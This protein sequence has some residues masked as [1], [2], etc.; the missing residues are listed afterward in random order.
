[1]TGQTMTM[2]SNNRKA[3]RYYRWQ[4]TAIKGTP[5]PNDGYVQAAEFV[6]QYNGTDRTTITSS[7]TATNPSG[8]SPTGEEPPKLIDNNLATK[9][10]DFNFTTNGN[11][12]N[13]V[14]TFTSSY[15]FTGYRWATANDA[16]ARDPKS[17]TLAG[18]PDGTNW[19]TLHTV[20]NF[21]ATVAR[22]TWQTAQTY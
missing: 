1:M 22:D 19:T 13:F 20:T 10:L 21:S 11:V 12:S 7:A 3:Y 2:L 5:L 6:F 14:F 9:W 17:W 8:S 16:E 4:I 15:S 18:S